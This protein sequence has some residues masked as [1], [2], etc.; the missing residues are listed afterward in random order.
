MFGVIV[1]CLLEDRRQF[2]N[3]L[4]NFVTL[5]RYYTARDTPI[6]KP[7][8]EV[9]YNPKDQ[10]WIKS[11]VDLAVEY[12]QERSF[13]KRFSHAQIKKFLPKLRIQQF[14]VDDFIFPDYQVCIILAGSVECNKHIDEERIS[15]PVGR[16]VEGDI[17]GIKEID[18]GM[19]SH[20]ESWSRCLSAVEVAWIDRE[21]FMEMWK[22]QDLMHEKMVVY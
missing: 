14:K 11:R 13:F 2:N 4:E 19:T 20:L 8:Y 21:D 6:Q 3:Y 1:I 18:E 5:L 9:F 15:T 10:K 16:Y 17:L 7:L 22:L 12:L